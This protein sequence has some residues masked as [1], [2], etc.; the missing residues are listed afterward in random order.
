M[1]NRTCPYCSLAAHLTIQ[2]GRHDFDTGRGQFAA[3]C[4]QCAGISSAQY[5][6]VASTTRGGYTNDLSTVKS[7]ARDGG[8]YDWQ[9]VRG[10]SKKIEDV[11]ETVAHAAEEAHANL[12][13]GHVMSAI[14]MARAVIEACAK[15][16]GIDKGVLASKIQK[17]EEQGIIRSHITEAATELRHAGNEMAHGDFGDSPSV[18]DAEDFLRIMD[19]ILNEVFQ[20]PQRTARLR[21]DREARK[22]AKSR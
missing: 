9:P 6:S 8:I 3:T 15:N 20:S 11:P 13:V 16:K 7:N 19:E 10:V 5:H 1:P 14:I 22:K 17:L 2:W 12:S 4:D 18:D 21:A